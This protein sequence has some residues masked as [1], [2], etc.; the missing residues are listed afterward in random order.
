MSRRSRGDTD[1]AREVKKLIKKLDLWEVKDVWNY[2]GKRH[3]EI[4]KEDW[5]NA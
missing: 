5:N 3:N 4:L 1:K 2:C